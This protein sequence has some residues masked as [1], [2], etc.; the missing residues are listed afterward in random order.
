MQY[1]RYSSK[2]TLAILKHASLLQDDSSSF[3]EC[4]DGM[5]I[6][7]SMSL[8]SATTERDPTIY[9]YESSTPAPFFGIQKAYLKERE[10]YQGTS[11][12]VKPWR[13]KECTYNGHDLPQLNNSMKGIVSRSSHFQRHDELSN[14]TSEIVCN[15]RRIIL[16]DRTSTSTRTVWTPQLEALTLHFFSLA[17]VHI[18]LEAYWTIWSPN[19]PVI[20]R[21]TFDI[22]ST[23][24][25]LFVGMVILGAC[26]SPN[27]AD[28]RNARIYYNYVE[29]MVFRDPYLSFRD[30]SGC[31]N[32]TEQA[33]YQRR[34]VQA[35][36][37]GYAV[38]IF[39]NWDGDPAARKRI[40]LERFSVLIAVFQIQF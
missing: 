2:K 21:P 38:C 36:Q 18:F 14:K 19:W 12:V 27:P 4:H 35:I 3:F 29:E 40:R 25:T 28:R 17:K 30:W 22:L 9:E 5:A 37:A 32:I 34:F 6:D 20:H 15:L 13:H 10:Q 33:C 16:E 11:D 31:G 1:F 8:S 39:Q 23:P 24:T 7:N 26:H